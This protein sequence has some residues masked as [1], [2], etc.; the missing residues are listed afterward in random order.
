MTRATEVR[1]AVA[2]NLLWLVIF[3][4]MVFF[5]RSGSAGAGAQPFIAT[6]AVVLPFFGMSQLLLNHFGF[7]RSGFRA[8]LLSPVPRWQILLGKNLATLPFT[9]GIGL[10]LLL[11]VTL[12]MRIPAL[13]V[14]TACLQFLIALLLLSMLGNLISP[15]L[16]CRVAPGSLKPTKQPLTTTLLLI[17]CHMF[18]SAMLSSAFL[19]PLVGWLFARAGWLPAAPISLLFSAVELFILV[20]L[21]SLSLPHLGRLLQN[22]EKEVLRIVTQ[23]VE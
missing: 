5:R 14:L 2:S 10:A 16:P 13:V 20:V 7:D 6:A 9:M 8:L 21:Y 15:L 22:R 4:G 11:L 19:P 18:S 3:G 1:M 17:F 12:T 23:D